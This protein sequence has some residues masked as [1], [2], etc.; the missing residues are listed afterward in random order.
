VLP[1]EQVAE[2]VVPP[3][4][5]VELARYYDWQQPIFSG[6]N[7]YKMQAQVEGDGTVCLQTVPGDTQ[8][9]VAQPGVWTN[10]TVQLERT[11][12][13]DPIGVVISGQATP[14]GSALRVRALQVH[15]L[16]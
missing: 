10:V 13:P 8:C 12:G 6:Y 11:Y 4:S 14:G 16:P 15:V 9:E 5:N 1:I 3:G 7:V 2:Q